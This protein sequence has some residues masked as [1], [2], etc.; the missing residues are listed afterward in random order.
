MEFDIDVSGEDV[1]SKNFT[2]CIANKDSIIKGYK[3]S[4]EIIN[5]IS[6]RYGHGFY[7][8]KKSDKGRSLFKVRT[9]CIIIYYLFKSIQIKNGIRLNI[10]RD[11]DGK[12]NDI[13]SN[14]SFFLGNLLNIKIESLIFCRL[15][16]GSNAHRYSYLMRKDDKNQMKTYVNIKLEDIEKFLKK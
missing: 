7:K 10:C 13:K 11:F 4:S 15:G 14:L 5:I 9:Y 1:F 8:Y 2:I 12:E 6:S 3:L 16:E